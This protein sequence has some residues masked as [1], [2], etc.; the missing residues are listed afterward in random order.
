MKYE[1]AKSLIEREIRPN[2]TSDEIYLCQTLGIQ[3][4][5]EIYDIA[6]V[7]GY[8]YAYIYN[9]GEGAEEL[10]DV[11]AGCIDD[12][13]E[14]YRDT[15]EQA[16]ISNYSPLSLCALL[17]HDY[18]SLRNLARQNYHEEKKNEE[19]KNEKT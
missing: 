1:M 7:Y 14:T 13:I 5:K 2:P 11:V 8:E 10:N 18:K 16:E 17:P 19:S 3:K 4:L 12:V 15:V 6:L 9:T